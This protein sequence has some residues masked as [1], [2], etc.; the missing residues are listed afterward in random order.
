[1]TQQTKVTNQGITPAWQA[2]EKVEALAN[3]QNKRNR[4]IKRTGERRGRE[5]PLGGAEARPQ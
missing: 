3:T 4:R 5:R 1:V 2:V